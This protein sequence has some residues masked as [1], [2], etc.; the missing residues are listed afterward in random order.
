M[1]HKKETTIILD[2]VA[3]KD[4]WIW[5]AF[6]G[7][8]GSHNDINV[9]HISHILSSLAEGKGPQFHNNINGHNYSMCYY[10][11]NDISVMGNF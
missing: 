11:A 4:L 9:L 5:H 3:S 1:G 10:L 2:V 7:I 6:F 8:L